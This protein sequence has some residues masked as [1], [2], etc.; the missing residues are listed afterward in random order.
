MGVADGLAFASCAAVAY[1]VQYVPVKRY[2]I[3]DGATFQWFMCNGIFMAGC[4][5]TLATGDFSHAFAKEVVF[6]GVLWSLSNYCV[7]PLVK[8][9]GIGLGFS[10]YHFV[11]MVTGY[12]VGRFGIFGLAP[13][14]GNLPVCDFG[15]SLILLSFIAMLFVTEP[16]PEI[17]EAS[18]FVDGADNLSLHQ[19]DGMRT[20]STSTQYRSV[21]GFATCDR[22]ASRERF[23]PKEM[24]EKYRRGSSRERQ[25]PLLTITDDR[26]SQVDS[27]HDA[28][29]AKKKVMGIFLALA[30]GGLAGVQS[31]PAAL[32]N[33]NHPSQSPTAAVFPH[34]LGIWIGSNVIY[35][36]YANLAQCQGWTVPHAAIR[37]AYLSGCIWASGDAFMIAGIKNLGFGIGYTLD[38][39][40]PIC[41]ASLLAIFVFKEITG[42]RQLSIYWCAFACQL[43]GVILMTFFGKQAG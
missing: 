10:L 8:L 18:S 35:L 39:V 16:D 23:R 36:C 2:E 7:L 34:C 31:V 19:N 32:Y 11:N 21:G 24:P 17:S 3:F 38:A 9:L 26:K 25:Q 6:G 43:V 37:P 14:T 27:L 4:V 1:G 15:C 13:M 40:G 30:A 28:P 22:S 42:R 20:R 29:T 5:I 33:A 41:V 12:I